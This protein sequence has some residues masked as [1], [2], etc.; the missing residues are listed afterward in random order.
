MFIPFYVSYT[1]NDEFESLPIFGPSQ[2][3]Y[4]PYGRMSSRNMQTLLNFMGLRRQKRAIT[5]MLEFVLYNI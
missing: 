3:V 5:G 1:V 2:N 4:G